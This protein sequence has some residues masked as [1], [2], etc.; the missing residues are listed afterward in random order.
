VSKATMSLHM[1]AQVEIMTTES[2]LQEVKL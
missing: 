1:T 2:L